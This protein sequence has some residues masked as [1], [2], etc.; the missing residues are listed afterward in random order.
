LRTRI[1]ASPYSAR[2]LDAGFWRSCMSGYFELSPASVENLAR[3]GPKPA[4]LL[5]SVGMIT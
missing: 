1:D 3:E 2:R 5:A 4:P